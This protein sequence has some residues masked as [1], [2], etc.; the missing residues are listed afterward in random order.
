LESGDPR[1]RDDPKARMKLEPLLDQERE[2]ISHTFPGPVSYEIPSLAYGVKVFFGL[3]QFYFF[4]I[5]RGERELLR[6]G[7]T[8]SFC[9][10]QTLPKAES[11]GAV[12]GSRWGSRLSWSPPTCGRGGE[13][14]LRCQ[15]ARRRPQVEA[16]DALVIPVDSLLPVRACCH[17][18]KSGAFEKVA[19]SPTEVFSPSARKI[20]SQRPPRKTSLLSKKSSLPFCVNLVFGGKAGFVSCKKG[21]RGTLFRSQYLYLVVQFFLWTKGRFGAFF[22]PSRR[23]Y[24]L[25]KGRTKGPLLESGDPR[26]RDDPKARMKLEPLLDQER[27]RISHTFPRPG[28]LPTA[29]TELALRERIVWCGEG[30]PLGFP[31]LLVS[32]YLWKRG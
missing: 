27:E 26:R 2:R 31:A 11:C 4:F 5:N 23:L 22:T 1:R 17:A 25:Y 30:F 14:I 12:K 24:V 8:H 10:D 19:P 28:L 9:P 20:R 15:G 7:D 18:G 32:T 16:T 29:S 13:L 21:E 6:G 3:F